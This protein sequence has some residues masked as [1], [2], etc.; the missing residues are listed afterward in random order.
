[1]DF[2]LFPVFRGSDFIHKARRVIGIL[3]LPFYRTAADQFFSP[4]NLLGP[5]CLL[6]G[7]ILGRIGDD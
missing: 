2:C 5:D 4:G 1:M 7:G 3:T 6:V